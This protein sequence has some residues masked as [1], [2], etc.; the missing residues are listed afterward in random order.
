VAD[1]QWYDQEKKIK[2]TNDELMKLWQAVTTLL[3]RCRGG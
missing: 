3:E 1:D 2:E